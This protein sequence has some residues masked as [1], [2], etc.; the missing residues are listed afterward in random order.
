MALLQIR[1]VPD[2]V[3]DVIRRRARARGQSIQGFMLEAVVQLARQPDASE[4]LAE[5]ER[6]LANRPSLSVDFSD[7]QADLRRDDSA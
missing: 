4:V 3:H 1:D 7:V 6:D 2:D 5:L